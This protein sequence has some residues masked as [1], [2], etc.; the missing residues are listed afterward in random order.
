MRKVVA[1]SIDPRREIDSVLLLKAEKEVN[2]ERKCKFSPYGL[3]VG[4]T[5]WVHNVTN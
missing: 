3:A 1:S 5:H 4:G 2:R